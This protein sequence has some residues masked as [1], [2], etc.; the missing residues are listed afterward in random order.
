MH[1]A[2]FRHVLGR[3]VVSDDL[4]DVWMRGMVAESRIADLE[5]PILPCRRIVDN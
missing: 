4:G 2:A 3:P 1:I 5:G